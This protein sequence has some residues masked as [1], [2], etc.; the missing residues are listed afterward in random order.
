MKGLFSLEDEEWTDEG[1]ALDMEIHAALMP[2]LKKWA[3]AGYSRRDI[4]YVVESAVHDAGTLVI[5]GWE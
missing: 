3:D 1:R 2:I 5:L 4:H